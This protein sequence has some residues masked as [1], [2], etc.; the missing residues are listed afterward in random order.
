MIEK[1][2]VEFLE[3]EDLLKED[4][5]VLLAVSGGIDSVV[6]VDLF[7]RAKV[8]FAIAHCNFQLRGKESDNDEKFV[9][10]LAKKY[11]VT[12]FSTKFDTKKFG[13][14]NKLSIQEAARKLRYEWFEEI[15]KK[16]N[17]DSIATAHHLNDSIETFFINLVRGTGIEGLKGIPIKNGRIIRPLIIFTRKKIEAYAKKKKLKFREDSS[18]K[19]DV[20]LRNK[21]RHQLIPLLNK[22]NPKFEAIMEQTMNNLGFPIE[23]FSKEVLKTFSRHFE[24]ENKSLT[25]SISQIKTLPHPAQYLYYMLK[26]MNFNAETSEEILFKHP[27]SHR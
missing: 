9:E 11:S 3:K 5:S 8:N 4:S 17:I 7:H 16:H 23:I 12:F 20:Y 22:L 27:C 26:P 15:C 25:A 19:E 21:I 24:E 13:K 18:N 1:K 2:F 6:M 14:T 10:Q